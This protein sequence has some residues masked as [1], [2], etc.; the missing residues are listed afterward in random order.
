[1]E[2]SKSTFALFFGNRSLVPA[3]FIENT[4]REIASQLQLLGYEVLMIPSNATIYGAV[5]TVA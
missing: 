3:S 1:M 4:R 5:E 2:H